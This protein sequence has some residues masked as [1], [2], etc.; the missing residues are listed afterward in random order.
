M[1]VLFNT[2]DINFEAEF[3]DSQTAKEIIENLPISSTVSTWGDEIYFDIKVKCS[4]E[5][6]TM[7]LGAP[8]SDDNFILY[9]NGAINI[10]YI[11]LQN[12]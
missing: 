10:N 7:D 11:K 9:G 2:Q 6:A 5:N 8:D 1:K 12:P 4:P 3:N